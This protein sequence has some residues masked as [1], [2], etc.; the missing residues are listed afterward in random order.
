MM[1]RPAPHSPERA[2]LCHLGEESPRPFQVS[3]VWTRTDEGWF[4]SVFRNPLGEAAILGGVLF[5]SEIPTAAPGLIADSPIAH[6]EGLAVATRRA[7][8]SQGRR[9]RGRIAVLDPFVEVPRRKTAHVRGDVGLRADQP[10]EAHELVCPELVWI[11]IPWTIGDVFRPFTRV[12]PEV[13]A[14]RT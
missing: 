12:T 1:Q 7:G 10:A 13:R 5:R 11:V 14:A 4:D 3:A 2:A 6:R 8:I 9:A